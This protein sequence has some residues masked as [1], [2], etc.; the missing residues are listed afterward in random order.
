M[1]TIFADQ[2]RE[3]SRYLGHIHLTIVT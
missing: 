3:R 2:S 1:N